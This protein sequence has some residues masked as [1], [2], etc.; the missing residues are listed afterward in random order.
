MN[1]SNV[2]SE[3]DHRCIIVSMPAH[4][5]NYLLSPD[6]TPFIITYSS[7]VHRWSVVLSSPTISKQSAHM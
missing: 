3:F 5:A 2:Y 7:F 6:V 4:L 1:V